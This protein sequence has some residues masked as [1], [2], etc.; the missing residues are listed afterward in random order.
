MKTLKSL[1]LA[2]A[3]QNREI[4]YC[5]GMNYIMGFLYINIKDEEKTYK[6][7]SYLIDLYFENMFTKD[8]YKL[9]LLFFQF[10]RCLALFVPDLADHF[11]VFYKKIYK[12]N[13]KLKHFYL[14]LE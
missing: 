5:Q 10:E 12:T 8:L 13:I 2:F 1:L 11:K 6:C 4:S 7:F 14:F 3:H 9:K